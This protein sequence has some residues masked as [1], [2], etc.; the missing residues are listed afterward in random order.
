MAS[1][2]EAMRAFLE[3]PDESG[4]TRREKAL[5]SIYDK[6][7]ETALRIGYGDIT[8]DIP[9]TPAKEP[10]RP[11]LIPILTVTKHDYILGK[12]H[13]YVG[14]E[15]E[16]FRLDYRAGFAPALD[17]NLPPRS[18]KTTL[19]EGLVAAILRERPQTNIAWI[20]Y[21]KTLAYRSSRAIRD[22]LQGE[23]FVRT[24]GNIMG[25]GNSAAV[26]NW[27]TNA[28]GGLIARGFKSGVEGEN[29]DV[30]VL[31]D[32]CKEYAAY[33]STAMREQYDLF[34]DTLI[35]RIENHT[36]VLSIGRRWGKGDTKDAAREKIPRDWRTITIPAIALPG[37]ILKRAPGEAIFPERTDA[38]TLAEIQRTLGLI[39]WAAFYQQSPI[40][41][42]GAFFDRT[43]WIITPLEQF[44]AN[45]AWVRY[46]DLG[47]GDE[48]TS[49][50][51]VGCLL[52]IDA[53]GDIWIKHTIAWRRDWPV[54]KQGIIDQR[55]V[56]GANVLVGVESNGSQKGYRDD[57]VRAGI[58]A[59]KRLTAMEK[60][61]YAGMWQSKQWSEKV[62]LPSNGGLWVQ[63]LIDQ[64]HDF[65]TGKHDDYVD[66]ISGA[67]EL[68]TK[69]A[70]IRVH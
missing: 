36:A 14:N 17:I 19:A 15:L 32:I 70:P 2:R 11:D 60:T 20:S 10:E 40:D 29:I 59:I 47:F 22:I 50:E 58:P 68:A 8:K 7:P 42:A 64:C 37:D 63:K 44:P 28:G 61:V 30:I 21:N 5:R 57:L 26:D 34:F 33:L 35:S 69:H 31:D 4:L 38:A 12:V 1:V 23:A 39:E 62:H 45:L 52:G 53:T 54:V 13:R 18:G 27:R 6:T 43:K 25:A 46:Y 66:A 56:D 24:F 51:T 65:P 49:D 67:Y 41:T 9:E 16:K 3:E 55:R 48:A